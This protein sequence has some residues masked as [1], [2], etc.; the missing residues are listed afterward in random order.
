MTLYLDAVW[1]LNLLIDFMILR[2]TGYLNK[3]KNSGWRIIIGSIFASLIVFVAVFYPSSLLLYPLG[4]IIFSI[5]IIV[6]TFKHKSWIDL[7]KTWLY[8]HFISFAIGGILLGV[9]FIFQQ[10]VQVESGSFMT[11]TTGYG[12]PISWVFVVV[13][14]PI[15]W[16]FTK[17][18]MD[19]QALINF[20]ADQLFNCEIGILGKNISTI[21]YLDSANHLIDPVT[22][23]PVV[24]IDQ[25][26]IKQ[27]FTDDL[28]IQLEQISQSLDISQLDAS[29]IQSI[30]LIPYQD[31][32]NPTGVLIALKPELFTVTYYDQ[33]IESKNILIGLRFSTLASEQEYH[34]LLNPQLFKYLQSS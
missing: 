19:K 28:F 10:S 33:V 6:L 21:G 23:K 31:V 4:K 18:T 25:L 22:K 17:Q 14:F 12:T 8:F 20:Q 34:C 30:R 32:S 24:I 13:G 26:I 15:C 11:V 27:I 5:T 2:L 7:L 1:L 9:H 16:Y 29:L 3:K